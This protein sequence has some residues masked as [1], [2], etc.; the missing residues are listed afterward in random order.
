M[1]KLDYK[2]VA[3]FIMMLRRD[4]IKV[5]FKEK[6]I[7]MDTGYFHEITKERIALLKKRN[8]FKVYEQLSMF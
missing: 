1:R 2:T 8:H 3:M 6:T 4:G 7:M 5:N